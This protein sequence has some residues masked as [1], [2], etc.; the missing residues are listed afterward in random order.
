MAL[1]TNYKRIPSSI[2]DL[3]VCY[4]MAVLAKDEAKKTYFFHAIEK[5]TNVSGNIRAKV[6]RAIKKFEESRAVGA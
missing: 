4:K 2:Y 3:A 6:L 1:G 5:F